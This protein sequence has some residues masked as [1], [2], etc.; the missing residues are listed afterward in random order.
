MV[1]WSEFRMEKYRDDDH[2]EYAGNLFRESKFRDKIL[3]NLGIESVYTNLRDEYSDLK[4]AKKEDLD[5]PM[6]SGYNYSLLFLSKLEDYFDVC[7]IASELSDF[8]LLLLNIH[9][10]HNDKVYNRMDR[11]RLL[12]VA[13]AV[14]IHDKICNLNFLHFGM[15]LQYR[16]WSD[17]DY[18]HYHNLYHLV[19]FSLFNLV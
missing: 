13:G 11:F 5:G 19:P 16:N 7:R 15:S 10:L 8:L 18:F 9:K 2:R 3:K 12:P 6:I 17:R 1:I 4:N 14:A